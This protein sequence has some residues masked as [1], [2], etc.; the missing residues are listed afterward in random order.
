MTAV[1]LC[2]VDHQAIK[3]DESAWSKLPYVGEM[4]TYNDEPG[5]ATHL[6]LRNCQCSTTLCREVWKGARP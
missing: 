6:E 4:L 5:A 3:R 1:D 2:T